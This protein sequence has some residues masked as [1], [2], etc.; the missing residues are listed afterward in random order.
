MNLTLINYF[1]DK[2]ILILGFGLEGRVSFEYL[3]RHQTEIA[4]DSILVADRNPIPDDIENREW[5]EA[6]SGN[7]YLEAIGEADIVL[8]SPGISF[9][10]FTIT[11]RDGKIFLTE[12]PD[13]EITGQIDL[14]LRFAKGRLIGVS[15]TKGKSTTTTITH[16]I[17]QRYFPEAKLLGNIGVPVFRV[18]DDLVDTSISVI[19]MSSHQL[20]FVSAS[21]D[22]AMLTNFYPEHL[23]HYRSYDNYIDAKLNLIRFQSKDDICILNANEEE[24]IKKTATIQSGKRIYISDAGKEIYSS[25]FISYT[26]LNNDK[27]LFHSE[28]FTFPAK[29]VL[30]GNHMKIDALYAIAAAHAI[31]SPID[32]SAKAILD[33]EGIPHRLQNV[34]QYKGITFF[35]DSIATIPQASILAMET[36]G[37]NGHLSSILIG[38]MDRG[39]DY[40]AFAEY[41]ARSKIDNCI[42]FPDTGNIV[43]KKLQDLGAKINI[44][45]VEEMDEAVRIAYELTK[46][47]GIV[48][49]S[50]AASS[51]NHYKNFEERGNC[52]IEAVK[53]YS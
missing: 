35:N 6:R 40:S 9:K 32:E 23:D 25:S 16:T 36:V 12:Y 33:F 19:E 26:L 50:P 24:L 18:I 51:Y 28:E 39:I 21:P 44:I 43:A 42:C 47:G 27:F 15:G 20:E 10:D 34:G 13:T 46:P 1:K 2:R 11:R 49:L 29:H 45:L 38:G 48:L 7:N 17:L 37:E 5:I 4:F 31:G 41:I 22:I 52:F 14:F 3:M 53:K 8:K 30:L